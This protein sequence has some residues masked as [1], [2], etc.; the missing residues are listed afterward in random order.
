MT[1]NRGRAFIFP[2]LFTNIMPYRILEG[3]LLIEVTVV[4]NEVKFIY[5]IVTTGTVLGSKFVFYFEF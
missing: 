2:N 1:L 5:C 3:G 4:L